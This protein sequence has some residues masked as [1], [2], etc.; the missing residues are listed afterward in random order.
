M[1]LIEPRRHVAHARRLLTAGVATL[2][3]MAA[4]AMGSESKKPD[5]QGVWV[6]ISPFGVGL[7]ASK[8][9]PAGK[10]ATAE[11]KETYGPDA[12][13]AG[14]YCVHSGM[15]WMMLSSAGYPLEII[16]N[17]KQINISVET[18]SIR[19]IFLDGRPHP[20]DRPPSSSGHS[21]GRWEGDVLVVETTLLAERVDGRTIS[22]EARIIE[23]IYLK[24]DTGERRAAFAEN[25]SEEMGLKRD[26]KMLVDE[27]TV[28]DPKFYVEPI[29]IVGEFRRAPDTAVLE[30]DCGREFWEAA[31]EQKLEEMKQQRKK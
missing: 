4:P 27:I 1:T 9:T 8:L 5:I 26:G 16:G 11:F 19:R 2:L 31:L 17:D 18:G 15:P 21:V 3:A 23:R 25:F 30:Y 20:T 24:D 10:K 22:D 7:P 14:A 28:I 6:S 12:P 29:K 13:E